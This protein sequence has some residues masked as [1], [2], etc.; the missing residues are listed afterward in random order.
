MLLFIKLFCY[1]TSN[2]MFAKNGTRIEN[3]LYFRSLIL[4]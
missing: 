1:F 4:V 3:N 2:L